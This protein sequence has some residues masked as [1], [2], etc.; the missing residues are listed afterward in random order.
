[1]KMAALNSNAHEPSGTPDGQSRVFDRVC[2]L[3]PSSGLQFIDAGLDASHLAMLRAWFTEDEIETTSGVRR[4]LLPL[5]NDAAAD[6][7]IWH[8]LTFKPLGPSETLSF[9]G[10]EAIEPFLDTW[11]PSTGTDDV[12]MFTSTDGKNVVSVLVNRSDKA[13]KTVTASFAHCGAL[14][15]AEAFQYDGAS[16]E[17]T[18]VPLG[19]VAGNSVS[20]ELPPWSVTTIRL[21][22][23]G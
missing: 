10:L 19:A 22:P 18:A 15:N 13:Q 23:K 5:A 7:T 1:M 6:G 3:V 21:T 20:V 8:P 11:V 14:N 17:L 12:S 4:V 2:R 9:T 16:S